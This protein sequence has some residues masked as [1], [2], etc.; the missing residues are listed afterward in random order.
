MPVQ[1]HLALKFEPTIYQFY[2]SCKDEEFVFIISSRF[3]QCQR[4]NFPKIKCMCAY[5]LFSKAEFHSL[6]YIRKL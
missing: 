1:T 3:M 6:R 2:V 5:K 4:Q